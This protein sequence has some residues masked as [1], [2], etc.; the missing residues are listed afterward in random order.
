MLTLNRRLGLA[1]AL[2]ANLLAAGGLRAAESDPASAYGPELQGFDYPFPVERYEFTSQRQ[3]LQMAYI[4]VR[5]E[6]P[7]GQ[8]AVLLHG[9]NFCAAT[10][11]SQI[12]ALSG[13]G[14]RVVAPDQIGFCKSSKPAAYQ[15]SFRQLA[16]NT[17]ALLEKLGVKNPIVIGHST[18]GMLAA[19]YALLYPKETAQLVLVNPIGLEDWSAKGVPPISLAQ[20][21]ERDL[22][23][24]ADTIRA[25]E[26]ATYYAGHWEERYEPWV[27]ML[28][29]MYRGPGKEQ[30][31]WNSALLYDMI[32]TQPVVYRLPQ[33]TVPT[34]L[35][36]GQK[37][38]TAIG[39]DLAPAEVKPTLGHYPEL[40]KAAAK[41][42]PGSRLV[43]FPEL[44]HAPQMSD[45]NGFNKALIEGIAKR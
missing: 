36:I 39:K 35:M 38:I 41:A 3:P 45:P 43:E 10:W 26:K 40:G 19:H 6:H 22:K 9:K 23:T 8:T 2:A 16:E 33:I 4:D 20:W 12:R 28:A 27:Q 29:G 25:Y 7:N 21:L 30:L 11:D 44:G 32:M 42:I 14:Y 15:F 18:G 31:A 37:D 13:A 5:P 24:S 34:L 17:H 1:I